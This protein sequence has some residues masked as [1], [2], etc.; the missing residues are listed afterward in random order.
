M[1]L[2]PTRTFNLI[3]LLF[4]LASLAFLPATAQALEGID[5][6]LSLEG[7]GFTVGDIIPIT[8]KVSHPAGYRVIPLQLEDGWGELEIRDISPPQVTAASDCSE[9]TT[10][11]IGV[12]IWSPGEYSTPELLIKVSD[13]SGEVHEISAMP[14]SMQVNSVLIDGD[15]QLRD[16][17]P[18]AEL[19]I[20]PVWPWVVG[21]LVAAALVL[22]SGIWFVRRRRTK[23]AT[24]EAARDSRLPHEVALD[25]LN[26]IE[27]LNL[28]EKGHYK[29]YYTLASDVLRQYLEKSFHIPTLDRTTGEISRSLKFAPF[30]RVDK[31]NLINL[32]R[33]ADLVKFAKIRPEM[34]LARSYIPR[35][36][37]TVVTTM[38]PEIATNNGNGNKDEKIRSLGEETPMM[39]IE[40]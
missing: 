21:G 40:G 24:A 17:K 12:T 18:Q 5:V 15:S 23:Q 33:D 3:I 9:M 22:A 32:L 6:S 2:N 25:E 1:N 19:P 36:R 39:E 13:T 10:Q 14:L 16:I 38:P 35:M 28:P 11:T 37:H 8:L 30:A 29:E 20:P 7:S 27:N 4:A 34:T 31:N 26:R